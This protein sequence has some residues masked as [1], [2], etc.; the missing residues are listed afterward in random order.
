MRRL[1]RIYRVLLKTRLLVHMQYRAVLAL[2]LL[3]MILDPVIFLVVWSTEARANGGTLDGY[4]PGQFAAYFIVLLLV[5]HLTDNW[6]YYRFQERVREGQLSPVLLRPLHPIHADLADNLTNKFLM[7]A[8]ILPAMI[9]LTLL[10]APSAHVTFWTVLAFLPALAFAMAIRF[11]VEW[12]LALVAFWTTQMDAVIQIYY[13]AQL[14][15]SGKLAPLILFPA[16]VQDLA[17]LSPFNWMIAFPITVVLGWVQPGDMALGFAMQLLWL[18]LSF[19]LVVV[20]WKHGIRR[21][22]AVGA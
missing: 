2:W 3:D 14:F 4:T 22:S 7:L 15:L 5:N 9:G 20:L 10:F 19:G 17:Y 12:A 6:V 18:G 1:W 13:I 21:Y 11:L 8:V 16:P